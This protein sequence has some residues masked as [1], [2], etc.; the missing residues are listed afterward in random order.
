MDEGWER[1]KLHCIAPGFMGHSLHGKEMHDRGCFDC[2]GFI[3]YHQLGKGGI[4]SSI[5]YIGSLDDE[6]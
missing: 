2:W 5:T 3:G 1:N 6:S 4:Q